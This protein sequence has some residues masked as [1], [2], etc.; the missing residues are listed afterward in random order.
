[1]NSIQVLSKNNL[2]VVINDKDNI[3]NVVEQ[4]LNGEINVEG[5]QNNAYNYLI[6][7][8]NISVIQNEMLQRMNNVCNLAS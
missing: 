3:C 2:A 5:I 8:K 6:N 7:E 1:M 4:L